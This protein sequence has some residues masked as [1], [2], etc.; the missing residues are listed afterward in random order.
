MNLCVIPARGGSKR[1]PRKNIRDFCGKPMI[2]YAI[3]V[4][5]HCRL[6]DRVIV[7]TDCKETAA[8]SQAFGAE[9]PFIRPAALS[10]DFTPTVDVVRHGLETLPQRGE[11]WASV[12]CL[13]PAVP[14]LNAQTLTR[15]FE[16]LATHETGYVFPVLE[17]PSPIERAFRLG[18][19]AKVVPLE[20]PR[21]LARTQ[22]LDSHYYDAGQF[23]WG[24]AL[25]WRSMSNIHANG[26]G[27]IVPRWSAVDIDNEED[28]VF[29]EMLFH[30]NREMQ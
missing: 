1:I 21:A 23:Y 7:S 29:A 16:M 28:W 10:D 22:D 11:S 12:C 18:A 26:Y 20:P 6:F 9:V 15:A 3:E 19:E 2:A 13:Y 17:F 5:L 14:L 24:S 4:A 25:S 8:I 27:F 30:V